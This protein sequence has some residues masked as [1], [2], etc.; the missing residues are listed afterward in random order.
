M[1]F[2]LKTLLER[3]QLQTFLI[4]NLLKGVFEYNILFRNDFNLKLIR[5]EFYLQ[6]ASGD[7]DFANISIDNIMDAIQI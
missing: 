7:Y 1:F 2:L 5:Y 6:I 3:T 4:G